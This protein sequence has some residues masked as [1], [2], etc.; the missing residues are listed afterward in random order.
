[1]NIN[2]FILTTIL[3][4]TVSALSPPSDDLIL[5]RW[6]VSDRP[7][8]EFF[9][10][11]FKSF[12]LSKPTEIINCFNQESS[13]AFFQ[14]L[15]EIRSVLGTSYIRVLIKSPFVDSSLTNILKALF[16]TNSCILPTQDLSD[17]MGVL[18]L[19]REELK[20]LPIAFHLYYQANYERLHSDFLLIINSLEVHKF[21]EAGVIAAQT[22]NST[23]KVI[24][25]EGVLPLALKSFANGLA[26]QADL[27]KFNESLK[28]YDNNTSA[29]IIH[30]I[31]SLSDAV[32][33][34][35]K[36]EA[37]MNTLDFWEKEGKRILKTLPRHTMKCHLYSED[38]KKMSKQLGV[39][40][41]TE[42]FGELIGS[43]I[44]AFNS[45]YYECSCEIKLLLENDNFIGAGQ[46]FG[47]YIK[48][49]TSLRK[50]GYYHRKV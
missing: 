30:F 20:T 47:R 48:R 19:S 38:H 13:E 41:Y 50:E 21:F 4:L 14:V 25:R 16:L 5:P 17:L 26:I 31:Y 45:T 1:M 34:G 33:S 15:Y 11:F 9:D 27:D 42:E 3:L 10:G 24:R 40:L 44:E 35:N 39:D 23:L 28:C 49:Q 43:S 37:L 18:S 22:F 12:N 2:T 8:V 46:E 7:L 29:V 36:T 32:C 6:F